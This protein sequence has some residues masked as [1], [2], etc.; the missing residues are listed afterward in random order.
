MIT[1][2]LL[3][4]ELR[5][6]R[7]GLDLKL[8]EMDIVITGAAILGIVMIL[9]YL[10][11]FSSAKFM[12]W[13]HNKLA[14]EYSELEPIMRE[15]EKLESAKRDIHKKI[16]VLKG[17]IRS[18]IILAKRL[19]RLSDILPPQTWLTKMAVEKRTEMVPVT[20]KTKAKT[21][22]VPAA[23]K[24]VKKNYNVFILEG[25]A[26]SRENEDMTRRIGDLIK[27]VR[28]DSIFSS[29]FSSVNLVS[30]CRVNVADVDVM[31]FKIGCRFAPMGFKK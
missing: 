1:I 26:L 20:P 22:A 31:S 28:E 3:P 4:T 5:K 30:T 11:S 29:D 24:K 25:M 7:K 12:G 6:A 8:P 17:L 23:G 13:R 16:S 18:R 14:A 2:N 15:A 27:K 10:V 19:N 9:I 21:K